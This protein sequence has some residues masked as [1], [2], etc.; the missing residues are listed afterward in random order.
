MV[1][2]MRAEYPSLWQGGRSV[3]TS[4]SRAGWMTGR[5]RDG[6]L[7]CVSLVSLSLC[8]SLSL[9]VFSVS[10]S[11]CLSLSACGRRWPCRPHTS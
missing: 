5:R 6:S 7:L 11:L 3:Y 9:S 10:Q 1:R 8:L 4:P 2:G